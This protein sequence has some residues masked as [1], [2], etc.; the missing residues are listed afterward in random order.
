MACHVDTLRRPLSHRGVLFVLLICMIGAGCASTPQASRERD[1]QAKTFDTHPATAAI[2]VYR[3]DNAPEEESV[4]FV[5]GRLIGATLPRTYFRF[6][7][8][9]GTHRLHGI[10]A[11]TGNLVFEAHAGDIVFISLRVLNGISHFQPV[12]D[13]AG[14]ESIRACCALL[15]NWA[16][17]QRPLIH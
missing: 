5:D 16:P 8:R 9:P 13:A 10:G 17:G 7:V 1:A 15:E 2:Y 4:L 3:N 12:S 6:N 14:R 11:D